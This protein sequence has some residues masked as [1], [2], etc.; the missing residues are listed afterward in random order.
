M[1]QS[2]KSPNIINHRYKRRYKHPVSRSAERGAILVLCRIRT[3]ARG[4]SRAKGGVRA[5]ATTHTVYGS[6][7][8]ALLGRGHLVYGGQDE[9]ENK[10]LEKACQLSLAKD[11]GVT[12]AGLEIRF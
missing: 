12:G 10:E 2:P 1:E 7:E 9:N 3:Q 8:G 11:D 4:G 6:R 5:S